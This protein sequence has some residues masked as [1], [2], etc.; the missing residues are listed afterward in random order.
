MRRD[1][2]L[3]NGRE[4]LF[5]LHCDVDAECR[6]AAI[7]WIIERVVQFEIGSK[8]I[9]L[10]IKMLDRLLVIR[11]IEQCHL[12]LTAVACLSFTSKLENQFCPQ[13]QTYA[14][15]ADHQFSDDDLVNAELD[16]MRDLKYRTN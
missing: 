13:L 12:L 10:G 11:R 9:F 4:D 7:N 1:D 5:R 14:E 8:A 16:V 6:K 15:L 2:S 3:Y